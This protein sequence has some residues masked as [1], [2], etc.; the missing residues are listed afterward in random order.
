MKRLVTKGD[1]ITEMREARGW[2][3]RRLASAYGTSTRRV[4]AMETDTDVKPR[5]EKRTFYM[6]YV[7]MLGYK[8]RLR[9]DWPVRDTRFSL[10]F[11]Q[12]RMIQFLCEDSTVLSN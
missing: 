11:E 2:S 1:Q 9:T 7:D 6:K 3:R 8:I 4:V 10:E 5:K 12:N